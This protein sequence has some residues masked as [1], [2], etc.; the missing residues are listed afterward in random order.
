ML[1]MKGRLLLA[2]VPHLSQM[3]LMLIS[4][5]Y[6]TTSHYS[7]HAEVLCDF[8]KQTIPYSSVVQVGN[9]L[10]TKCRMIYLLMTLFA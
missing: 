10:S 3:T 2:C 1:T 4:N 7:Y 5:S 9:Y 6:S 8:D